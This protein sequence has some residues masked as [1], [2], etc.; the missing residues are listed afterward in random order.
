MHKGVIMARL[1]R[2][3]RRLENWA[4]WQERG[5]SGGLGFATRSVLLSETWSRGSYNGMVIPVIEQ[6]AEET[7]QAVQSLKLTRPQLVATLECIY[8]R[9]LG[10][11]AT[12]LRMQR[13]ESTI[14]AQLEQADHAIAAW[15]EDRAQQQDKKRAA[16]AAQ[17]SSPT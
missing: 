17:R 2:I 1:E 14:K 8:L 7:D 12:A 16:T 10:V 5:V 3:K 13:A 6:E 15:L 11:K 9:D 4:M